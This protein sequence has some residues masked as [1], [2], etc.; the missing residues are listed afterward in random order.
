MLK[1]GNT[2]DTERKG[3]G[4]VGLRMEGND[5]Y[6]PLVGLCSAFI[7]ILSLQFFDERVRSLKLSFCR[8]ALGER[9]GHAQRLGTRSCHDDGDPREAI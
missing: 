5:Q 1:D 6:I 2:Y 9:C 4:E 8:K 3:H 7:V